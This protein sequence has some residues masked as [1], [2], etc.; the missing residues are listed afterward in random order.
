MAATI[1]INT[2]LSVSQLAQLF[3][4]QL[5]PKERTRLVVLL[6]QDENEPTESEKAEQLRLDYKA[7]QKGTLKTRPAGD[8]LKD[9]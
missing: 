3:R 6:Q 5:P 1:Q 9:L 8:F 2:S 4:K 7:L